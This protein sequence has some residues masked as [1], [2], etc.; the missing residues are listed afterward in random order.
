[1]AACSVS[2]SL[3]AL[4]CASRQSLI[5]RSVILTR[6]STVVCSFIGILSVVMENILVAGNSGDSERIA[7]GKIRKNRKR[8]SSEVIRDNSSPDWPNWS[9]NPFSV[10]G[11]ERSLERIPITEGNY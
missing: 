6:S 8:Y 1:M 2:F 11:L 4:E 3:T 10:M 5:S 7:T 9:V